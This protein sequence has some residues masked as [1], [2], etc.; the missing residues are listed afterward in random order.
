MSGST[1]SSVSSSSLHNMSPREEMQIRSL[2]LGQSSRASL[3]SFDRFWRFKMPR[4]S[5][6]AKEVHACIL[7]HKRRDESSN[8]QV[9]DLTVAPAL[10]LTQ[11]GT[12]AVKFDIDLASLGNLL[13]KFIFRH[14]AVPKP[15]ISRPSSISL[16]LFTSVCIVYVV[17]LYILE[18]SGLGCSCSIYSSLSLCSVM[19]DLLPLL[20]IFM[21]C[22]L[23]T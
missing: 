17:C 3:S 22:P 18:S 10:V 19:R 1:L 23:V 14:R 11:V 15:L 13:Y 4:V 5:A 2:S 20:C 21:L 7:R 16:P 8:F 9:D 12:E 6:K